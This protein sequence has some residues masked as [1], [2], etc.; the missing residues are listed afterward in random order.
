MQEKE[1]RNRPPNH[2]QGR[3]EEEYEK[4]WEINK[5]VP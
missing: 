3:E 4:V 1:E 2:K 5:K